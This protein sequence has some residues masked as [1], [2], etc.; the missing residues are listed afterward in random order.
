VKTT[1]DEMIGRLGELVHVA[2][3]GGYLDGPYDAEIM[4]FLKVWFQTVRRYVPQLNEAVDDVIQKVL[5]DGR[6]GEGWWQ[7]EKGWAE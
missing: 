3:D 7:V 5:A 2:N 1:Y 6:A 4:Y